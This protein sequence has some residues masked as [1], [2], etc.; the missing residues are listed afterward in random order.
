MKLPRAGSNDNNNNILFI[1]RQSDGVSGGVTRVSQRESWRGGGERV[2]EERFAWRAK[3][4]INCRCEIEAREKSDEF[5]RN[6]R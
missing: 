6:G 5:Q 4:G 1:I 3:F 2:G